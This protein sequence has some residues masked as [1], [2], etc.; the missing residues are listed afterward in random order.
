MPPRWKPREHVLHT[1][2]EVCSRLTQ[3]RT[4]HA[5]IGKYYAKFVPNKSIGCRS[6][7]RYQ[8][9]E[10]IMQ[11]C[12]WYEEHQEILKDANDQLELGVLLGMR[13]DQ[14]HSKIPG[15]D[16]HISKNGATKR[17]RQRTQCR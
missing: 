10:H 14:G 16:G 6:G 11:T 8:S 15:K 17:A 1:L 3:C 9:W 13:R 7:E 2:R 4:K 5:F 12:L